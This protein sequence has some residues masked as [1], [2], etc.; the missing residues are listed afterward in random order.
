MPLNV[1]QM[2]RLNKPKPTPTT[3]SFVSIA[4]RKIID[5]RVNV[6][7]AIHQFGHALKA[8]ASSRQLL[9]KDY[10]TNDWTNSPES[11]AV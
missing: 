11:Y 3:K 10:S 2:N 6:L 1:S 4:K 5:T 9:N 7:L 8:M